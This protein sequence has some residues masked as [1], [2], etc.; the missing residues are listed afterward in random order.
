MSPFSP[1]VSVF[2]FW[3]VTSFFR[4]ICLLSCALY[5]RP[6][7]LSLYVSGYCLIHANPVKTLHTS[8]LQPPA[9]QHFCCWCL[10]ECLCVCLC[11]SVCVCLCVSVC[12]CCWCLCLL[13]VSVSVVGVCVCC[14]CLCLVLVSA[15]VGS[16]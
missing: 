9:T 13:L 2:V 12:V 7:S 6:P 11:V 4:T 1:S 16:E 10:C 15:C 8:F 5:L 14:W 3:P